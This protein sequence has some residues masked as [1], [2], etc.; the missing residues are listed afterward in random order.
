VI[1]KAKEYII[2]MNGVAHAPLEVVGG[3]AK[4]LGE[5]ASTG[6]KFPTLSSLQVV[7]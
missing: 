3:E 2:G 6:Y 4:E 5:L 7:L 1:G